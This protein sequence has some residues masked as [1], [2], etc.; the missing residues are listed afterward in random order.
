MTLELL[1]S[2][3]EMR[4][5]GAKWREQADQEQHPMHNPI[6]LVIKT[7]MMDQLIKHLK[8]VLF[9]QDS[10]ACLL[11]GHRI[12]KTTAVEEIQKLLNQ[13]SDLPVYCHYFSVDTLE[14]KSIKQMYKLFCYQ[15]NIKLKNGSDGLQMREL[16]IHRIV[17]RF[18]LSGRKQVVLFID[19]LQRLSTQQLQA[20]ASLH[21]IFRK[22]KVNLCIVFVGNTVPSQTVL[23]AADRKSNKLIYGRFFEH[24]KAIYGI[25]SK[26][27]LKAC[28]SEFDKLRFPEGGPSYTQHFVHGD[29]P[30]DWKLASLSDLIWDVYVKQFWPKIKDRHESFGMKY[31]II[32]VRKLL[33]LHLNNQW[34]DDPVA[35]REMVSSAI[36]QSRI[37]A[38]KVQEAK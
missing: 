9:D 1:M 17:D 34:T 3:V 32:M 5:P 36:R 4:R 37:V 33:M 15:E 22:M 18:L 19:E 8:S 27:D 21:D 29:A 16:I 13:Q 26:D 14:A 2:I 11:G 30:K 35:L 31:F 25:R 7:P 20:L 28:L 10:G 6:D 23:N 38:E 12:G 24:Q